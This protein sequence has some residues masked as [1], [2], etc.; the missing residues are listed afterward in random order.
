MGRRGPPPKPSARRRL[1]GNPGKRALPVHEVVPPTTPETF[2]GDVPTELK[3]HPI[4]SAE[5]TRLA[6][7][8]WR[9]RLVTDADKSALLACCL[10]WQRYLN[11][12]EQVRQLGMVVNTPSGYPMPN[13]YVSIATR[14]LVA[15]TRLW[16]E[17]GLTP[18]SRSRVTPANPETQA[19]VVDAFSE[20]DV[21]YASARKQ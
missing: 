18:S 11:A 3:D 17:L 20:F 5:W 6:P 10:E 7:M 4:A 1:E 19:G 15:C 8:L 13:P 2:S 16:Q 9:I 12:T 14:A 21:P